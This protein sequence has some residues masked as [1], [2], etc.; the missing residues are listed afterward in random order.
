MSREVEV[1]RTYLE[2]RSPEQLRPV[3]AT[4]PSVAF[5]HRPA[6]GVDEYRRLY[7]AVGYRWYWRD[8]NAWSDERLAAHLARTEI[9]VWEC[10]VEG[11]SA[12]YFELERR[13]DGSVEIA[14]FGLIEAF[15]GKG[16]GKAMLTRAAREAWALQPNR[17]WLHTCTLDSPHA[18]PNYEARGFARFRTETYLANIDD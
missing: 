12:G 18:L 5:V 4:D 3:D 8:R 14:Y 1:A 9:S 11:E 17:V 7:R 13:D 16:V 15:V 10:L 6:I 2:L